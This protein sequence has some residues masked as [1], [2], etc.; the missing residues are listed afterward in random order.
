MWER[1]I[2]CWGASH[3]R[4]K[5]HVGMCVWG[6]GEGADGAAER[7]KGETGSGKVDQVEARELAGR[8]PILD[9]PQLPAPHPL[10]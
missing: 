3:R 9:C 2:G 1:E 8:H 10:V 4:A 7:K 6:G 5:R